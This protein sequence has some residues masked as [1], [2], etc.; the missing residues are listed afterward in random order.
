M[1]MQASASTSRTGRLFR[2]GNGSVRGFYF[3]HCGCDFWFRCF[4]AGTTGIGHI[5]YGIGDFT[6]G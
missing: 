4:K 3:R 2:W 1:S 6:I 5:G